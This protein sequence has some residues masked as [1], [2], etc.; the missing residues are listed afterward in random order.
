MDFKMQKINAL[1]SD[2]LIQQIDCQYKDQFI[3]KLSQLQYKF[4]N[5]WPNIKAMAM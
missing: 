3:N 2:I 1:T 4:P 5:N